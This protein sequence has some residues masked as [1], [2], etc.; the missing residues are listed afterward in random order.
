MTGIPVIQRKHAIAIAAVLVIATFTLAVYFTVLA[1][2]GFQINITDIDP[3]DMGVDEWLEDWQ[4]L[5]D[6]V[7][8]NYPFLD[9]KNRTHGYDWLELKSTY[10]ARINNAQ[11]NQEFL[12]IIMSALM[13]LQNRHTWV[14]YPANVVAMASDV[15]DFYPLNEIFR[16]EVVDVTSYWQPIYDAAWN[17]GYNT[18]Y[19]ALIV[20]DR[21]E[22]VVRNYN[23]SWEAKFGNDT[24]VTHVNGV[25]V[26]DAIETLYEVSYI[27]QD[28]HRGKNYVWSIYPRDFGGD[29][30]FTVENS[31]GYVDTVTFGVESGSAYDPYDYPTTPVS[32]MKYENESIGYLYV[33]S[34]GGGMDAYYDQLSTFYS[35]IEDYDYLIIDIRGNNGGFYSI[36]IDGIVEPLIQDSVIYNQYLGFRTSPYATQTQSFMLDHIVPK[37]DFSYLPPEAQTDDY[38]IYRNH[39]TFSPLGEFNFSGNIVALMDNYVYSAAEGFVNFC[40]ETGFATLYGTASGGDGLMIRPF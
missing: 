22:Y 14:M 4:A 21:G 9:V 7:E 10:E 34:F 24:I 26:D 37:T 2:P 16:Q 15:A 35:D 19:N 18:V 40:K 17:P 23:A 32:T 11:N 36:W 27:D 12:E 28:F 3:A 8:G 13:A 39:M 29:A 38:T 33:G 6:F 20:Y 25:P 30:V 31:T 5:Y 1:P